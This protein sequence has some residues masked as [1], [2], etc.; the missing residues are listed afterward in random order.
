MLKIPAA[1][2]GETAGKLINI[3]TRGNAGTGDDVLIGGFVIGEATQDVMIFAR[4]QEIPGLD[5]SVLLADPVLTI[6]NPATGE[7]V[8]TNDDWES[9]QA[10]LINQVW[11]RC[12]SGCSW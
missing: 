11:G 5:A 10:D 1:G 8:G 2:W 7:V 4:A 12:A 9:N 3:S 6:T